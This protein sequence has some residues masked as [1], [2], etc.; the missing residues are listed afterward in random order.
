MIV[1]DLLLIQVVMV[2][3]PVIAAEALRHKSLDKDLPK[4]FGNRAVDEVNSSHTATLYT[5]RS[6]SAFPPALVLWSGLWLFLAS[7][8]RHCRNCLK[9]PAS[10]SMSCLR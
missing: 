3:D 6:C 9:T 7:W 4:M 2:T 10:S 8:P 1:L 5:I